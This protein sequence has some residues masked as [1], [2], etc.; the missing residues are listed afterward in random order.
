MGK[1]NI[2]GWFLGLLLLFLGIIALFNYMNNFWPLFILVPGLIFEFSYFLIRKFPGVLVPGGILTTIGMLYLFETFTDWTFAEYT[3]PIYTL[4]VAIGLFQL[5]LFGNKR[6]GLLI[7]IFI[8]G[9][10][11]IIA[12]FLMLFGNLTSWLHYSLLLPII[13]IILGVFILILNSRKSNI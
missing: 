10:I 8:L 2:L 4:S 12:Y 13:L 11:S 5:Y 7:P 1:S 6:L 3:W 9:G